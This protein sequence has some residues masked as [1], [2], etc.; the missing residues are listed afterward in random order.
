MM[1][2]DFCPIC[3]TNATILGLFSLYVIVDIWWN[4]RDGSLRLE[5]WYEN[6]KRRRAARKRTQP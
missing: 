4:S 2:F 5:A 1:K 6:R 3:I